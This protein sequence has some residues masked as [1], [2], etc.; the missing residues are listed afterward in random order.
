MIKIRKLRT[1]TIFPVLGPLP[2]PS[3]RTRN[4]TRVQGTI[5]FLEA[6]KILYFKKEVFDF[7]KIKRLQ[8]WK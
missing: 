6:K 8:A 4:P 2:Q 3:E 1:G 7:F 5:E